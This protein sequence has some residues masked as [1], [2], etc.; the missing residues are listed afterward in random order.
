MIYSNCFARNR[1]DD[2]SEPLGLIVCSRP[3]T[4]RE[5]NLRDLQR[6][7]LYHGAIAQVKVTKI[8]YP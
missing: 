2:T 7:G 5:L 6:P 4:A 1:R 3:P 8:A